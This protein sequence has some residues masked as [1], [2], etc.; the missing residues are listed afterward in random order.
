MCG[1]CSR[2]EVRLYSLQCVQCSVMWDAGNSEVQEK[3][4]RSYLKEQWKLLPK[5]L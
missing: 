4:I 5:D 2:G 1:G 3:R